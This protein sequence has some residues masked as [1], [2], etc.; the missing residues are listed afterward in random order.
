VFADGTIWDTA[1]IREITM[2]GGSG[3]D[4]VLGYETNDA[5]SGMGGN[6]NIYGY[7]GDD[8]I[9]GGAGD[10]YIHGGDGS[11]TITGGDGDDNLSG[12]NGDDILYGGAGDDT[13]NGDN[14]ND[15]LYGGDGNDSMSGGTGD[16]T[17][18]FG[19]GCGKDTIY[20]YDSTAGN[21]DTVKILEGVAP[22]DVTVKRNDASIELTINGT[23]DMLT[24]SSYLY[25]DYNS[26][27]R[28][29]FADGTVWDA[30]HI[31]EMA[32]AG[33]AENDRILGYETNDTLNGLGGNDTIYGYA[34]ND[35]I[36]GGTGNDYLYGGDNN[37]IILGN[38]DDD[39]IYGDAGDDIL[40]G[41]SGDDLI[42]G[43]G[44][45]DIMD[46]GAGNDYLL[47]DAGNDTYFFNPGYGHDTATDYDTTSGNKDS[48][49][50][51]E[52]YYKLV[53]SQ[54]DNL[55]VSIH[56]TADSFMINGWVYGAENQIEEF[57][58]SDGMTL[59][60]TQVEQLIQA[61]AAFTQQNGITWD[62]AIE[63]RPQDVQNILLQSWHK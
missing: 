43:G 1:Y 18:V 58:A 62:Q 7:A 16:D 38:D 15:I 41:G 50:I 52:E 39:I 3:N 36:D 59:A 6:D 42:D 32:I 51:G 45:N 9:D 25:N 23:K 30:A 10:D 49:V 53:F 47:G 24:V 28:F 26:V 60:N 19:R 56:G 21:V 40:R 46:G 48:L 29:V 55:G 4:Y 14:G 61:M 33:G 5:L 13:L 22:T 8:T 31:K 44:E 54:E 12:E 34:G 27:E 2:A 63:D 11:D 35:T 17:Y 20:E 37:D 57:R